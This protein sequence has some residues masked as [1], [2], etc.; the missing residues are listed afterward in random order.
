MLVG[1]SGRT[2][3]CDLASFKLSPFKPD[4]RAKDAERIRALED[5]VVAL[6]QELRYVLSHLDSDNFTHLTEERG[7]VRRGTTS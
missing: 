3:G 6:E 2:E 7:G 4:R 5:R 1:I